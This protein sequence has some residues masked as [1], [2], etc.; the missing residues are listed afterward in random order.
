MPVATDHGEQSSCISYSTVTPSKNKVIHTNKKHPFLT[1]E[2]GFAPVA[3][4]YVGI[5]V[6]KANES[7][8]VVTGWYMILGLV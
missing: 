3:D 1:V 5:H 8:D 7:Y 6:L 2:Q 4:L